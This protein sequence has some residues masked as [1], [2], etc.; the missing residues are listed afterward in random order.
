MISAGLA[1]LGRACL[2]S[3]MLCVFSL[4]CFTPHQ[5]AHPSKLEMFP[6]LWAKTTNK[7]KEGFGSWAVLTCPCRALRNVTDQ[8]KPQQQLINPPE[9]LLHG[10][11]GIFGTTKLPPPP[12]ADKFAL[13]FEVLTQICKAGIQLEFFPVLY[14]HIILHRCCLLLVFRG[15]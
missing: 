6:V 10:K 14:H 13:S 11:R 3:L 15:K 2:H 12:P 8:D 7:H 9:L 4:C 1:P 5:A